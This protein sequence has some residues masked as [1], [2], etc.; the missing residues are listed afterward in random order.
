MIYTI[1]HGKI[2]ILIRVSTAEQ[3][4]DRQVKA[5]EN[6]KIEKWFIEKIS[7]KNTNRPKLQEML[8]FVREGDVI[9]VHDL[10]R[11]AR[12]TMDLLQISKVLQEKGVHLVSNKESVDTTTP[13]G[14][15]MFTMVGAI[16]EFERDVILERQREGIA[17]AKEK[18]KYKGRKAKEIPNFDD[19][20]ERYMRREITK[21]EIQRENHVSRTVVDRYFR[22]HIKNI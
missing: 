14:K 12:S 16:A 21:A 18:G 5:L 17:L 22:D 3:N 6:N 1:M 7:G 4:E 13:A 19:Y 9:Y 15:L 11:M 10:S 20:Y 8:D 2:K